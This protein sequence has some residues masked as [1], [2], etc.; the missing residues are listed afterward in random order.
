MTYSREARRSA[1]LWHTY[2]NSTCIIS[3]YEGKQQLATYLTTEG[4]TDGYYVVFDHREA[5]EKH[6]E[7]ETIDGF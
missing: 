5:P 4:V 1:I 6:T 2:P 7:T 3:L